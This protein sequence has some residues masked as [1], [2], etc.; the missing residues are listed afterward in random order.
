VFE[1]THPDN[2]MGIVA[3][4]VT[5]VGLGKT[6]PVG[7][8]TT[9]LGRQQNRRVELIVSGEVIGTQIGATSTITTMPNA[10][11]Q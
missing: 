4:T 7:P 6:Q 2:T 5:S 11:N 3:N 10:P 9:A 1:N 8:N